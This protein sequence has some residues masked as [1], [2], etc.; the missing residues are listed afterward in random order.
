MGWRVGCPVLPVYLIHHHLHHHHQHHQHHHRHHNHPRRR[1][2]LSPSASLPTPLPSKTARFIQSYPDLVAKLV[3]HIKH[4]GMVELLLVIVHYGRVEGV[5][6]W[7]V[8][9]D[10]IPRLL[11]RLE[12]AYQTVYVANM[13]APGLRS[14]ASLLGAGTAP[15]SSAAG[16]SGTKTSTDDDDDDDDASGGGDDE[17]APSQIPTHQ[18]KADTTV[19][20]ILQHFGLEDAYLV[21][22]RTGAFFVEDDKMPAPGYYEV[23]RLPDDGSVG[24]NSDDVPDPAAE[25]WVGLDADEIETVHTNTARVLVRRFRPRAARVGI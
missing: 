17:V 11:A 5:L 2:P 16:S 23:H 18:F 24:D 20:E 6:D 3:R 19:E 15:T 9:E 22:G 4:I 7:L 1:H 8:G 12:P 13:A 14:V 25:Q 21:S 10:I